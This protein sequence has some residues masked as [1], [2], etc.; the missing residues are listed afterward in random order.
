VRKYEP[1]ASNT[2]IYDKLFPVFKSLYKNNKKAFHILNK[3]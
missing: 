3:Q 1:N 2:E